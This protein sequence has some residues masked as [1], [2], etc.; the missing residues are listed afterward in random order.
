MKPITIIGGGL[1]GLT[2]GIG[3]RRE[4]VPVTIWEA[5][6]YPRHRVCGE[7]ISGQGQD[8]LARL[9]LSDLLDETG[10]IFAR[11]ATFFLGNLQSS[12]RPLPQPALCLSRFEMDAALAREFCA[13]GGELRA[14]E[15]WN[16]EAIVEG[17]IRANGRRRQASERGCRW[18]GLKVHARNVA[19]TADL[20]MHGSANGYVGITRLR[21]GVLNVCGLFRRPVTS[22]GSE[23]KDEAPNFESS[24]GF[25]PA[26][27]PISNRQGARTRGA[28][29]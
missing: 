21:D 18:F 29:G 15:R 5:G 19:S 23:R 7:F 20:E 2:L 27:S 25:Q 10:A 14:G 28:P 24:A 4:G 11:T 12:V 16:K 9:G 17:V 1:A 13:L 3:L 22:S 8:A 6:H 26:V